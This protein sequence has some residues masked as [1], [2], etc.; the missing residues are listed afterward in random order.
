MKPSSDAPQVVPATSS[1]T[2]G[3]SEYF[4]N[5]VRQQLPPSHTAEADR[6]EIASDV[7]QHLE[8][9]FAEGGVA[10]VTLSHMQEALRRLGPLGLNKTDQ[11]DTVEPVVQPVAPKVEGAAGDWVMPKKEPSY[12]K[13]PLN[14]LFWRGFFLFFLPLI[15]WL[16]ELF[17]GICATSFGNPM[18]TVWHGLLVGMVPLTGGLLIWPQNPWYFAERNPRFQRLLGIGLGVSLVI[19]CYYALLYAPLMPFSFVGIVFGVGLLALSPFFAALLHF[20]LWRRL[21]KSTELWPVFGKKIRLGILIA[22]GGIF[23]LDVPALWTRWAAGQVAAN[24]HSS[25]LALGVLRTIGQERALREICYSPGGRSIAARGFMSP[26]QLISSFIYVPPAF[27]P[28]E[29]YFQVMGTPLDKQDFPWRHRMAREPLWGRGIDPQRGGSVVGGVDQKLSLQT[30]RMDWHVEQS[31]GLAWGE[32]TMVF[33]NEAERPKEGRCTIKLPPHGAVTRLTL[34]VNG[35]P[36][37]AAYAATPRVKAA[38]QAVAVEQ[39]RD[40]VLITQSAPGEVYMQCFPVPGQGEMKL[41]LT[42]SAPVL[43]DAQL[44]LPTI[45]QR[46]F[47]FDAET[48][49]WA[50]SAS[51]ITLATKESI[52]PESSIHE[53]FHVLTGSLPATCFEASPVTLAMKPAEQ[54]RAPAVWCRNALSENPEQAIAI[55]RPTMAHGKDNPSAAKDATLAVVVDTSASMAAVE[56]T[57]KDGLEM[58]AKAFPSA[59][60]VLATDH[61]PIIT[62]L[63][64]WKKVWPRISWR[65]GKNNSGALDKALLWLQNK[66]MPMLLWLHGPQPSGPGSNVALDQLLDRLPITCDFVD[67]PLVS[68]QNRLISTFMKRP[69]IRVNAVAGPEAFLAQ[70]QSN[71]L[72]EAL[73]YDVTFQAESAPR[74]PDAVQASD[75]V[76]RWDALRRYR[77]LEAKD[78]AAAIKLAATHQ[79]V[80]PLTG[81]VVLERASDYTNN[82]LTQAK[83]SQSQGIPVIPEPSSSMLVLLSCWGLAFR[84]RRPLT[85]TA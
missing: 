21:R 22:L 45:S 50:Q 14:K 62:T 42:I 12:G 85:R 29:L 8:E 73:P 25:P 28:E 27:N 31:T 6:V 56:G 30:N 5:W 55:A 48:Q 10:T 20:I 11:G 18:P 16:V 80:T 35:E 54:K 23:L 34:W 75:T 72:W 60:L 38:Y 74:P 59:Q 82:G 61:P 53:G 40:P 83:A 52:T 69:G 36:Q 39:Q 58:L 70:F 4:E 79:L 64:Q 66:P 43:K 44:P 63:G 46:N 9:S 37:E 24:P 19:S 33:R 67:C 15:T 17:T 51:P 7:R 76:V 2:D 1:W 57:L 3:A 41:R 84:R 13:N 71:E 49:F 81:A 78:A 47:L 65:G 68:G 77:K 32:W 26:G